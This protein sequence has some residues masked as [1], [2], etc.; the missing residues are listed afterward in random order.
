MIVNIYSV[1]KYT[2]AKVYTI[3]VSKKKIFLV[4]MFD[5]Q[6]GIGVKNIFD[7]VRK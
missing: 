1:E 2:N 5:V 6:E 3:R 4:R 7:L